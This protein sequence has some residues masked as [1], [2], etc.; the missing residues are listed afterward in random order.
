MAGPRSILVGFVCLQDRRPPELHHSPSTGL[1]SKLAMRPKANQ[2]QNLGFRLS[3]DQHQI[4]PE[5]A[6]AMFGPL[7]RQGVINVAEGERPIVR[8]EIERVS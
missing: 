2:F 6:I 7:A 1:Q 5:M 8:K 4:R 3:I